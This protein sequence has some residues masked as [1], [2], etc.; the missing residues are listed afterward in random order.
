MPN[1]ML[2]FDV[3]YQM[4]KPHAME[5]KNGTTY[6]FRTLLLQNIQ[7]RPKEGEDIS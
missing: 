1:A 6:A 3:S 7:K 4:P 5:K 2:A